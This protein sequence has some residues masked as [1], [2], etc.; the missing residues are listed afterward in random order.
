[1]NATNILLQ[2]AR[3]FGFW[4][5]NKQYYRKSA[6]LAGCVDFPAGAAHSAREILKFNFPRSRSLRRRIGEEIRRSMEHTRK[7]CLPKARPA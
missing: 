7:S 5:A 6:A 2:A 4:T 1:V 3:S